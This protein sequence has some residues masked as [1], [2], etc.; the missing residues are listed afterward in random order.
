MEQLA[1]ALREAMARRAH[2]YRE[3]ATAMGVASGTVVNWSKGWVEKSPRLEHWRPLAEYLEVPM[4][5][6]LGW[7]GL[8]TA[9]QAEQLNGA[10]RPYVKSHR[11]E[12]ALATA[13]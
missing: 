6:M 1:K 4:P 2:S 3:A 8:L 9:E 5:V 13:S 12:L 10:T 7:L 11:R